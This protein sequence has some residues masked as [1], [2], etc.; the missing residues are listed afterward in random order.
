MMCSGIDPTN[1]SLRAD[2]VVHCTSKLRI[3]VTTHFHMFIYSLLVAK[4]SGSDRGPNWAWHWGRICF[5]VI[6][7]SKVVVVVIPA[8]YIISEYGQ[9]T[10]P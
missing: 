8:H 2:G 10:C 6:F 3:E 5:Q 7:N 1:N 9:S 4:L